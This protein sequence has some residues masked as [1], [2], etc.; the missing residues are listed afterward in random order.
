VC[1]L[2]GVVVSMLDIGPHGRGFR[3]SGGDVSS[4]TI[5]Y[6]AQLPSDGK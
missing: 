5:K 3:P 6:A 2:G 1:G 4:M